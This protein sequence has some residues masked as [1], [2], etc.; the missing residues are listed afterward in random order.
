VAVKCSDKHKASDI[1][2]PSRDQKRV[3]NIFLKDVGPWAIGLGARCLANF[4]LD[5]LEFG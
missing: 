1:K 5:F 2:L 3:G 4:V